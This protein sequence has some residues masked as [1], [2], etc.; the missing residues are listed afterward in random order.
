MPTVKNT[1]VYYI[2]RTIIASDLILCHL[3]I[4]HIKLG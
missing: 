4:K 1:K 2:G 3:Y